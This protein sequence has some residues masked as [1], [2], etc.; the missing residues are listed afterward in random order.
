[1]SLQKVTDLQPKSLQAWSLLAGVLLQQIDQAKDEATK[2]RAFEELEGVII[3]KM[4]AVASSPR[5]YYIQMTRALV[6]MRKNTDDYRKRARTALVSAY[7]ERPEVTVIGEMILNIDISL[8]DTES[9]LKHGRMILRRNRQDKLANYVMGSIRLREGDY[10]SAETFL[11]LSCQAENPI[12]A[13][14][15][16]L[17]EVLR[18]LQR[19]SEAESFA[20]AAVKTSPKL[21]VAW[22]TLGSVL[23]DQKKN[24]DE[25]EKCVLKAIELTKADGSNINDIRMQITLA[26]VQIAKG[27]KARARGTLRSLMSHQKELSRYEYGEF[28]RLLKLANEKK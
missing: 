15:N 17:A 5:D 22:E 27:D 18:R 3:P 20:R 24:L 12:A 19:Y 28:E 1:M 21:Y 6:Y 26:R 16:D 25:S 8:N 10:T 9:A 11:R 4:E 13:A 7:R 14:Q 2:K 23:L